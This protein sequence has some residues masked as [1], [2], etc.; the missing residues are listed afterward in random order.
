[1]VT[2]RAARAAIRELPASQLAAYAAVPISF[3]VTSR[4]VR[5]PERSTPGA[6]VEMPLASPFDKDYDASPGMSPLDWPERYQLNRWGLLVADVEG[7]VVGG[8]AVAP[9]AE[10]M[11]EHDV[12]RGAAV[13]WD[14]RVAPAWRGQGIGSALFRAAERWASAHGSDTLII[15]TQDVNVP[16]CRLYARLGCRLLS[17]EEDAYDTTPREARLI[18]RAP[19]ADG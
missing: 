16:A 2:A 12:A 7:R 10:V 14:L 3:C 1:M 19:M 4:L 8:A 13:L 15:E 6:L 18:W 17:Y 11:A 5:D 9:A